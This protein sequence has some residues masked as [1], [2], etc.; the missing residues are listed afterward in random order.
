MSGETSLSPFNADFEDTPVQPAPPG[1]SP[2][3]GR[4]Y[5]VDSSRM[6]FRELWRHVRSP[7]V[8]IVWLTK[9]LRVKL[10]GSINDPNVGSL[11]PFVV[12]GETLDKAIPAEV[13]QQFNPVL[14]ELMD[15]GFGGPFYFDIN[16]VFHHSHAFHAVLVHQ[17]GRSIARLHLRTEGVMKPKTYL[18]NEFISLLN[19]GELL[20]SSSARAQAFP[21]PRC[22]LN[23]K[24][25]ATA[26]QL[27]LLHRQQLEKAAQSGVQPVIVHTQEEA[28]DVIERH[29]E[30]VR[31]AHLQRGVFSSMQGEDLAQAGALDASFA[32]AAA[33]QIRHPEVMAQLDRL[34]KR[35]TSW[36][37]A[38]LVLLVSIGLFMGA[39]ASESYGSWDILLMIV[40]IL[41]VHEA[42][43]YLAMKVFHYRNVR[44]FFIPFLGAAV[45]GQNYS[46]PGWKKVIVS[47]MGPLPGIFLGGLVGIAAMIKGNHLWMKVGMF[48]VILNGFQ[49]LPVLPLDGGRVMQT[50]LFCRHYFLDLLFRLMAGAALI[51]LGAFTG[52]KILLYLGVFMLVSS[53]SATKL[54]KIAT[55]L[56]R[57]G[58]GPT[59]NT[60]ASPVDL[61]YAVSTPNVPESLTVGD[62]HVATGKPFDQPG[63]DSPFSSAR[64]DVPAAYLV[65]SPV[66]QP[67]MEECSISQ[68]VAEKIIDRIKV[69]FPRVKSPRQIATLTM[70]AYEMLTSRPPGAGASVGFLFLHGAS[71]LVAMFL[72]ALLL[73]SQNRFFRDMVAANSIQPT[74]TLDPSLMRT[75]G[76]KPPGET[77]IR[78][79][80]SQS[81]APGRASREQRDTIVANFASVEQARTAFD[82]LK[83]QASSNSSMALVGQSVLVSLPADDES[84]NKKWFGEL[85]KRTPQLFVDSGE[86]RASL[87]TTFVAPTMP[88]AS[89]LFDELANYL[90]LPSALWLIPPWAG[91]DLDPRSAKKR[92]QHEVARATY[93]KLQEVSVYDAAELKSAR[94]TMTRALRRGDR[95]EYRRLVKEQGRLRK[96]LRARE[97]KRIRDS[98]Q[99]PVD[100][101]LAD[102]YIAIVSTQETE[103]VGEEIEAMDAASP[104]TR[105][106]PEAPSSRPTTEPV[107]GDQVFH[108]IYARERSELG[109]LLGQL[110]HPSS[111]RLPSADVLRFSHRYGH[112]QRANSRKLVI[113]VVF[114]DVSQGAPALFRWLAAR[115]CGEFKYDFTGSGGLDEEDDQ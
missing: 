65:N 60:N 49:L 18:F 4:F 48:A 12:P 28:M 36:T 47:L 17:D 51:G 35:Q 70:Q 91:Q 5:R 8:L 82:D 95:S 58:V 37:S 94:D 55:E 56:R 22:R 108:N 26:S 86:F 84:A 77:V 114:E 92:A 110:P 32:Q 78:P 59:K 62:G 21:P 30:A 76:G 72:V 96:E 24:Y 100:R 15:L 107:D 53:L 101:E 69:R 106:S 85:E 31:D 9:I 90:Q 112:V 99:E 13:W 104:V 43:H 79:P 113:T 52:D 19:N 6:S 109:P 68:P 97:L 64:A 29:H 102:R 46:A 20:W 45:S 40:G 61:P 11:R 73:V 103:D 3:A 83:K 115:G 34:Q 1:H 44:M 2:Q 81:K 93:R 80:E 10:P 33:G 111:G 42:G 27:W 87:T 41:L 50:I 25:K 23:W 98:E 88:E 57:E 105:P 66:N 39:G 16:D 38:I 63:I 74:R 71:F 7:A 67:R 89:K 14:R 75:W 54:A